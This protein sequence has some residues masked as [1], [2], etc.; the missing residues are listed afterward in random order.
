MFNKPETAKKVGQLLNKL[1]DLKNGK[2]VKERNLKER[3]E[4]LDFSELYKVE[5]TDRISSI[6]HQTTKERRFNKKDMLPV[7]EDL[8]KI[9][10]FLEMK[11]KECTE[12][13]KQETSLTNWKNLAKVCLVKVQTFNFRQGN[14]SSKMLVETYK[15]RAK[16]RECNTEI[17]QTLDKLERELGK[18]YAFLNNNDIKKSL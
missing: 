8:I 15:K 18:R 3:Q 14:E 1:A 11:I 12:M 4:S 16:W 9:Q 17:F 5:W 7:T 10:I 6:P 13:L 2:A